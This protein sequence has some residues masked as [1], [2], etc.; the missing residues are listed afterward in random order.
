MRLAHVPPQVGCLG[1][2][3]SISPPLLSPWAS[4]LN[5]AT[6]PS[7]AAETPSRTPY[8]EGPELP[9]QVR[10]MAPERTMRSTVDAT[11]LKVVPR[12]LLTAT[13]PQ[14]TKRRESKTSTSRSGRYPPYL[15][16]LVLKVC[17]V[18]FVPK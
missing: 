9:P 18:R 1:S 10:A 5:T 7:T 2:S 11:S 14:S 4:K 3:S 8:V 13:S 6:G 17:G 16:E 12:S 15:T